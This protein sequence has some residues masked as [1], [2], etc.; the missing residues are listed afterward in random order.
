MLSGELIEY[1]MMLSSVISEKMVY[2]NNKN[3]EWY[4]INLRDI[5]KY[6]NDWSVLGKS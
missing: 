6:R 3:S 5:E 2:S 4:A 1:F